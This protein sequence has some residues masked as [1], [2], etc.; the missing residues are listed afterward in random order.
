MDHYIKAGVSPTMA[1][2]LAGAGGRGL[3]NITCSLYKPKQAFTLLLSA[4][5]TNRSKMPRALI[6]HKQ[7]AQAPQAKQAE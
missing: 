2:V 7:S 6:P 4:P 3:Y 1:G 5:T